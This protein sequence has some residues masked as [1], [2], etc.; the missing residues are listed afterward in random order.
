MLCPECGTTVEDGERSC[1]NCSTRIRG[2]GLFRRLLDP[3][4][5]R[6]AAYVKP[7]IFIRVSV[8]KGT[9]K[10]VVTTSNV[11]F[12]K[13]VERIVPVDSMQV[14]NSLDELPAEVRAKLEEARAQGKL[15][16]EKTTER[17][18]VVDPAT[19]KE[20]VFHSLDELPPEVRAKFG[21]A[22]AQAKIPSEQPLFRIQGLDGK[23]L[24]TYRSLEEMP[25]NM[26]A[27]MEQMISPEIRAKLKGSD[28]AKEPPEA[29]P[30]AKDESGFEE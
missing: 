7:Y 21:E 1:P 16:A 26:R 5:R 4:V 29:A 20:Q 8:T 15:F 11:I 25:P 30:S 22:L 17:F 10:T 19:G 12:R 23:E 6:L 9:P 18:T 14:I 2:R 24:A 3:L 28:A 13:K 27:I